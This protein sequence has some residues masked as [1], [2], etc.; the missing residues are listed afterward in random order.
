MEKQL[1][2]IL[3][4]LSTSKHQNASPLSSCSDQNFIGKSIHGIKQQLINKNV[5]F[6]V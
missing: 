2:A 3:L 4:N 1:Y 6:W 5:I